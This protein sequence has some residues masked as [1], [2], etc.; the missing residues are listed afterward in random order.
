MKK[1]LTFLGIFIMLSVSGQQID[2]I[3]NGEG[4]ADVRSKLNTSISRGNE[5]DTVVVI[6][7]DGDTVDVIGVFLNNGVDIS[8]GGS[9]LEVKTEA[10]DTVRSVYDTNN[11]SIVDNSELLQGKD[12]IY[13]FSKQEN[14]L[15]ESTG[16]SFNRLGSIAFWN[17]LAGVTSYYILTGE[18]TFLIANQDTGGE[19]GSI[20]LEGDGDISLN[21]K[22]SNETMTLSL[23]SSGVRI[24]NDVTDDGLVYMSDYTANM[25]TNRHIP[26]IGK[27]AQMIGD[28]INSS[29]GSIDTTTVANIVKEVLESSNITAPG[30]EM[31]SAEFWES[32][33]TVLI[34]WYTTDRLYYTDVY[35]TFSADS[36]VTDLS[37]YYTQ[38]QVDS[39]TAQLRSD[40]NDSISNISVS[41]TAVYNDTLY[42]SIVVSSDTTLFID[43][44][45]IPDNFSYTSMWKGAEGY[46]M[47]IT[48]NAEWQILKNPIIVNDTTISRCISYLSKDLHDNNW[49]LG[50]NC[51]YF[52]SEDTTTTPVGD[53]TAAFAQS[54]WQTDSSFIKIKMSEDITVTNDTSQF[55][56]TGSS[57]DT[58]IYASNDTLTIYLAS[59]SVISNISYNQ[60]SPGAIKDTADNYT[61]S[62]SDTLVT[63]MIAQGEGTAFA[64]SFAY[65]DG[66]LATVS[67]A[68]WTNL[69]GSLLVSGNKIVPSN[70][71]DQSLYYRGNLG[72]TDSSYIQF[73]NGVEAS[74]SESGVCFT[75]L[76]G[77]GYVILTSSSLLLFSRLDAFVPTTLGASSLS[78]TST[79]RV[80]RVG[81]TYTVFINGQ[82]ATG[83][84]NGGGIY[85]DATHDA[86]YVGVWGYSGG[87]RSIDN[88]EG[89]EL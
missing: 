41:S 23:N 69:R 24:R 50:T 44:T 86:T 54:A 12:T 15:E 76:S 83:M 49:Y 72:T 42:Q 53:T 58:G 8:G 25:N 40:I 67:G 13:I 88:F 52:Y 11:N 84:T 39:I 61:L 77:N 33:D 65:S 57:Q 32:Q 38:S 9:G 3:S 82:V 29:G 46:A 56:L 34:R 78:E 27:I 45:G 19:S 2:T 55:L 87:G 68:L 81:S 16:F 75:D 48:S 36:S 73:I 47:T 5:R 22:V 18:K 59:K 43:T 20:S 1:T 79:I 14:Q 66:D 6:S 37:G 17:T 10:I 74:S 85:T 89:G 21:S 70:P 64:D 30:T 71:S 63:N 31:D 62:W 51:E 35:Y 28:S 4:G 60:G 26:D 7:E 80:R